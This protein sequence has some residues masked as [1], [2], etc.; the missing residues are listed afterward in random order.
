MGLKKITSK[1]LE[2]G[3]TFAI[4]IENEESAYFGQYFIFICFK[5]EIWFNYWGSWYDEK[6]STLFRIKITTNG[7]IPQTKEEIDELEFVISNAKCI[8][9]A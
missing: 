4:R 2:N 7:N 9:S 3:D 1:K 5:D 8:E 6:F